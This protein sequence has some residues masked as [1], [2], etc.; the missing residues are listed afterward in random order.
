MIFSKGNRKINC[1]FSLNGKKLENTNEYKYLGIPLHKKNCSFTSALKYLRTK[2]TRALY[3]LRAKI[4]INSLPL[5]I[6][7]KLFDALIKPILLYASEVWEP[8]V[9]NDPEHWDQ[10][11]IERTY[12]Q[13]LKQILG[14]NRSTTTAMA[15]GEL[16]QHSLQ[17]E[18]L[19]RNIK[20]AKYIYDKEEDRFVKHA[21]E[22][23]MNRG[24]GKTTFFSTMQ[25]HIININN[26]TGS[27]LPYIDPY[28]N[29]YNQE[30]IRTVTNQLFTE[31]W[32]RKLEN[33]TKCDTYRL[34]KDN[35]KIEPYLYH[36][37]RKERVAMTKLR[38]SD[39]KLAIEQGRHTRPLTP[40]EERFCH[41]CSTKVED[42]T[43]FFTNCTMYG[44]K[45]TFWQKI[46][47]KFPHVANLNDRD[48]FSFLM[49]QEDEEIVALTLKMNLEWQKLRS[50]LCEYFYQQNDRN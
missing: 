39:H 47:T 41:M 31:E 8:F 40:R 29:I 34:F 2:A 50:F 9:K 5:Y 3:A 6:A 27:F 25:K 37:N 14:V 30:N 24:E 35:M 38:V 10:N 7:N 21:Y 23:E 26:I 18:I 46:Y 4:N 28:V 36:R 1:S 15:R 33:S 44:N 22:Y 20:Y 19:R 12:T 32:R 13:F 43:H 48:K 16:N 49:T 11:E 42:E 45:D 17:E